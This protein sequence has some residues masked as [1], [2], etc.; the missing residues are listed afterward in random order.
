MMAG[1]L[2]KALVI[3]RRH[4]RRIN[5][6]AVLQYGKR[7]FL[8]LTWCQSVAEG[9]P[10]QTQ[11]FV[12]QGAFNTAVVNIAFALL[13]PSESQVDTIAPLLFISEF[14]IE[15]GIRLTDSPLFDDLLS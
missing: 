5:G 15:Q 1:Q 6:F 12:R 8:L 13:H 11:V 7:P 2:I 9:L 14:A 4:Q 10:L 3:H